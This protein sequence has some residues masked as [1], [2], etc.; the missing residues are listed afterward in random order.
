MN[1]VSTGI[2]D[3][4]SCRCTGSSQR[5]FPHHTRLVNPGSVRSVTWEIKT[6]Q[7]LMRNPRPLTL[8]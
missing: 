2:K 3:V 1:K 6:N 4:F 5:D 8:T 7:D